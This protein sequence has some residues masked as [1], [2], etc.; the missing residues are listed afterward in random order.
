MQVLR[1]RP[2]ALVRSL[3]MSRAR[4]G[5]PCGV[6]CC[7]VSESERVRPADAALS[8]VAAS[9]RGRAISMTAL[10]ARVGSGAARAAAVRRLKVLGLTTLGPAAVGDIGGVANTICCNGVVAAVTCCFAGG[11]GG[12]AAWSVLGGAAAWSV[13]GCAAAWS[14]L[15]CAAD[16][17]L[18]DF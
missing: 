9:R 15:G 1:S 5:W 13:I 8:G 4:L 3:A 17:A 12:A 10:S 11:V 18:S 7:Q 2:W 16:Q 6:E 14:A